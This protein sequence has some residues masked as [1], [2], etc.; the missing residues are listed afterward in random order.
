MPNVAQ[1]NPAVTAE[2]P[3]QGIIVS[4]Y[5][6]TTC[7]VQ[8]FGEVRNLS[9]LIPGLYYFVGADATPV[10]PP[11]TG[12]VRQIV[13]YATGQDRLILTPNLILDGYVFGNEE[14]QGIALLGP[15]DGTNR[16]FTTPEKFLH[17][18]GRTITVFHNGRRL[19]QASSPSP[20]LGEYSVS[21]SAG[22]GTGYDTVTVLSFAPVHESGLVADYHVS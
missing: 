5:T 21:E 18:L 9:G 4:K 19:L 7:L 1:V 20:S 6:L 11:P 13:G 10:T 3:S 15:R 8:V 2:M 17:T 14:R 22:L 16:V 12:I